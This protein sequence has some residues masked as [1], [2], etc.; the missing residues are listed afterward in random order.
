M[1][2][3]KKMLRPQRR[4]RQ[5]A[6]K[7]S[8]ETT[9]KIEPLCGSIETQFKRCGRSNCKCSKGELHGPYYLRRWQRCGK[10]RSKY[11]KKSDVSATFQACLEYKRD[12]QETREL[13]REINET[14]NSMLKALGEVIRRWQ[15]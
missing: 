7:K 10:R 8:R 13:I 14:G 15:P 11:V 6:E 3:K 9:T 4:D 2:R 12:R 5:T 1:G